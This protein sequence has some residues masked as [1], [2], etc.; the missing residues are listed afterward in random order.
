MKF[1]LHY[2][3]ISFIDYTICIVIT[4]CNEDFAIHIDMYDCFLLSWLLRCSFGEEIA[5]TENKAM[6]RRSENGYSRYKSI[7]MQIYRASFLN[8]SRETAKLCLRGY[9]GV[10]K[11]A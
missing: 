11:T 1:M 9:N 3:I 10:F 8:E 7:Q 2:E 6:K 5:G 4:V